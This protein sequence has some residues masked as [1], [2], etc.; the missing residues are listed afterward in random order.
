MRRTLPETFLQAN[1]A[2]RPKWWHHFTLARKYVGV[3]VLALM[4]LANGTITTYVSRYMTT[5]AQNALHVTPSLA[6]ATELVSTGLHVIGA[7]LGG[8]MADRINRKPVMIGAQLAV[9]VLTYPIFLWMVD[10]PGA[11]SLLFGFGVLSLIMFVPLVVSSV[12]LLEA[13]PQQ[14]RSGVLGTVY[15]VAIMIFGGTTQLVVTWLIHVT[16]HPMAP[17]WYLLLAAVVG[18]LA[19]MLMP[20]TAP[21]KDSR[22]T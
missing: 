10:A 8:W 21:A 3:I 11:W 18:L 9:L 19:M 4:I 22:S 13:L 6:F 2:A 17:A 1:D 12:T 15:A 20:E 5:Y 14:I 16:G 7:L